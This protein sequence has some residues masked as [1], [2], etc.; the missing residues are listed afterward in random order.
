MESEPLK[1]LIKQ[2][3][4]EE[5]AELAVDQLSDIETWLHERSQSVRE[6]N[7]SFQEILEIESVY[8]IVRGA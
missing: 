6:E 2:R 5:Q 1:Q 8:Q 3:H 7:L 4:E